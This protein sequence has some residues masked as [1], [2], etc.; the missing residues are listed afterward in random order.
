MTI[1]WN[2]NW[3][4][5]FTSR[6]EKKKKLKKWRNNGNEATDR[7]YRW[8]YSLM[9]AGRSCEEDRE[10]FIKVLS[11]IPLQ[12]FDVS[13]TFSCKTKIIYL[14]TFIFIL[15]YFF[16]LLL[17]YFVLSPIKNC[18]VRNITINLLLNILIKQN[19]HYFH[20]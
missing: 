1:A 5:S 13:L 7:H 16:F 4:S 2:W 15:F 12:L 17:D 10:I 11:T 3:T 19:K 20:F 14:F 18:R 8:I 9:H 6:F